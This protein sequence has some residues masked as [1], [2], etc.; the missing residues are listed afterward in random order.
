MKRKR[1]KNWLC[2]AL[3]VA[4]AG[5]GMTACSS[6]D[7][8]EEATQTKIE[9]CLYGKKWILRRWFMDS[10]TEKTTYSFFRNHLVMCESETKVTSGMLTWDTSLYFGTWQVSENK[11]STTFT[12]GSVKGFDWN[13]ILY[14][15]LTVNMLASNTNEIECTDPQG[16][17]RYLAYY[18]REGWTK[19]TFTDYTDTSDHDRALQGTWQMTAYKNG[20]PTDF[21]IT[22]GKKGDVH[23]TTDDGEIDFTSTCTTRNG[24]VTFSDYLVPG[25]GEKSYIY[26]RKDD[27]VQLFS[28][29]NAQ[30]L[31]GWTNVK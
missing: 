7:D 3:L 18:M 11:L 23:F 26:I 13:N 27:A 19:R 30:K 14:G 12:S 31:W 5:M 24:H 9:N 16:E 28:E 22:I 15:T 25:S 20:Q 29:S 2:A 10:D 6:D 4:C 8:K 17:T 1:M 21:T